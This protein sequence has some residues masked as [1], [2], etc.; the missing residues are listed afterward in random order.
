MSSKLT[1]ALTKGDRVL[2]KD[3]ALLAKIGIEPRDDVFT[4]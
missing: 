3:L 1:L 2:H 4:S